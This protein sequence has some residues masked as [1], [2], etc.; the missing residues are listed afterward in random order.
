M[1]FANWNIDMGREEVF[2]FGWCNFVKYFANFWFVGSCNA[3]R[4]RGMTNWNG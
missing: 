2:N 4:E 3:E 1:D